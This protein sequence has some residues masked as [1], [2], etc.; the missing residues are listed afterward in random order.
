MWLAHKYLSGFRCIAERCEDTCCAGL[1]IPLTEGDRARWAQV[2]NV[3]EARALTGHAELPKRPEGTCV[4]LSPE[5]LC[6]LQRRGGEG[7]LPDACAQFPRVVVAVGDRPE[8]SGSLACPEMTRRLLQDDALESG[9]LA[10]AAL[11]RPVSVGQLDA[12][13]TR[14]ALRRVWRREEGRELRLLAM[15]QLACALDSAPDSQTREELLQA[16]EPEAL[17]EQAKA[18]LSVLPRSAGWLTFALSLW[19]SI[20]RRAMA[21]TRLESFAART[22][23]A[24]EVPGD[25][26]LPAQEALVERY[27]A[28]RPATEEHVERRYGE[29]ALQRMTGRGVGGQVLR[30]AVELAVIRCGLAGA[31]RALPD[32]APAVDTLQL[33]SK[34]LAHGEELTALLKEWSA[35]S[36]GGVFT[37]T[38]LFL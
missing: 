9:D 32:G 7:A 38:V 26:P 16:Q 12:G 4:M 36:P 10:D 29:H 35:E 27:L 24:F 33:F 13:R 14:D 5:R 30:I 1:R 31:S 23:E 28:F 2:L 11:P 15:A 18:I 34:H 37:R 21:G 17:L 6:G 25:G 19:R 22:F 8:L 20:G 3:E